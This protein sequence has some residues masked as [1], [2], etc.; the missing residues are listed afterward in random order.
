MPAP[1]GVMD[2][3]SD[4]VPSLRAAGLGEMAAWAE[5]CPVRMGG[6]GRT[7]LDLWASAPRGYWLLWYAQKAGAPRPA[8]V[9]AAPACA[10]PALRFVPEGE[11]RPRLAVEA[12]EAW[13]DEPTARNRRRAEKASKAASTAVDVVGMARAVMGAGA[14]V[15][16]AAERRVAWS[17]KPG[18]AGWA[19]CMAAWAH[20]HAEGPESESAAHAACADEVRRLVPFLDLAGGGRGAGRT[21][22]PPP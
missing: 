3:P 6:R 5:A 4:C 10:R 9:R 17:A 8:L 20:G 7:C 21:A 18:A 13:A 14:W 19:A 15:A 11:D 22:S 12:A 16:A 1:G 2:R